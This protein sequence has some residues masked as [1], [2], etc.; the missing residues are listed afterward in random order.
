MKYAVIL[1]KCLHQMPSNDKLSTAYKECFGKEPTPND[2]A[3]MKIDKNNINV[4]YKGKSIIM[5]CDHVLPPK[6]ELSSIFRRL[7][8]REPTQTDFDAM[9]IDMLNEYVI[10]LVER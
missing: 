7:Y 2:I 3:Q 10:I 5:E 4:L 8:Y 1:M 9:K 6:E